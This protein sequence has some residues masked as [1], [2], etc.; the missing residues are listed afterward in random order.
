MQI[1]GLGERAV[2]SK[3]REGSGGMMN[4]IHDIT[5]GLLG[6]VSGNE[7]L[8]TEGHRVPGG[9]IGGRVTGNRSRAGKG[10]SNEMVQDVSDEG[11]Q[12]TLSKEVFTKYQSSDLIPGAKEHPGDIVEA[13]SLAAVPLPKA[14][15]DLAASIP[16]EL[17]TE[18]KLS[19]LQLEGILYTCQRHQ[20]VL[21]NGNRA[22]CF[23]GDAAG[24]GKG[25][26]IAGIILDN[27]CRG[28]TKHI[29]FS[30]SADL[31]VDAQR[32][33]HDLGCHIKVIEGCQ[34][35]DKETRVLGLP[36]DFQD[37]V[38]FSTYA[39]LVSSTQRGGAWGS[40]RQSRLE[41]LIQ[42][43]GGTEFNG[44]LV[45]DECHKAKHFIPGKEDTSTKVAVAVTAIQR[46]LPKAR[47][48]YCSATGVS[49][50][51]NMAFMER[52][53]MWGEGAS[54]ESFEKFLNA[55]NKRGLGVAEMMAMEMKASGMYV[56]R[57]LSFKQAEFVTVEMDLTDEQIK[58]Y[59]TAAHVWNELKKALEAALGRTNTGPTR[60]W[61]F[62]WSC[63]QRFFKQLCLGVK[64]PRIVEEAKKALDE[65]YCVV[66]GLQSTGEASMD[67]EITKAGSS[68][69]GFVSVA[70][71]TLIRFISQHFPTLIISDTGV[72][73][74]DEWS[75][76]AKTM[77]LGFAKEIQLPNSPLDD[78]I[79]QLGGASA[80]AE[81]TGRRGRMVRDGPNT[82]A[83]YQLRTPA[84][85]FDLNSLNVQERNSFMSG[86]KLVAIIS[87]AASTGISLH[88]DTRVKNQRRRLHLTIELPWSADKAVQQMG[89]SHR[90]NQ[91]SGPLYKLLTTN[92]GGER[93]F[94]ASVARRL[95]TLGALTQGD[96]RAATGA[97]LTQF[98]FDT[99]YG[100]SALKTMYMSICNNELATGV[101]LS[102]IRPGNIDADFCELNAELEE[103]L[104]LM[105]VMETY[106]SIG[107][108][109]NEND[110]K[111]VGRFLNRI[112]G[113]R[114]DRQN[115]I[116]NYFYECLQ[117]AI[118]MAKKEGKYSEGLVDVNAA[119]VEMICP[120]KTVFKEANTSTPTQLLSLSVDRGLSWEEAVERSKRFSSKND[121]FY[122]SKRE[123]FGKKLYILA[124]KKED[125]THLFKIAR[126]NTGVSHSDEDYSDLILRYRPIS[127]EDAEEGWKE[128][129]E[130]TKDKC[131]HGSHCKHPATCTIGSR[132]HRMDL[133]CGGIVTLLSTLEATVIKHAQKLDL[134]KASYSM[135]V[136]RV[137]LS[138]EKRVI[139]IRY[140]ECLVEIA[141][142]AVR[143]QKMI[144]ALQARLR[145]NAADDTDATSADLSQT[146]KL[147]TVEPESPVNPKLVKKAMTAP[148]T[149]NTFF[150]P[151]SRFESGKSRSSSPSESPSPSNDKEDT[152][153]SSAK[154]KQR[155]SKRG[156]RKTSRYS[157]IGQ[158]KKA[159]ECSK[160][161]AAGTDSDVDCCIMIE[162]QSSTTPQ[163]QN[164]M[165]QLKDCAP[166]Q[167][168]MEEV[169]D[170]SFGKEVMPA[171]DAQTERIYDVPD[172]AIP[173]PHN[174]MGKLPPVHSSASF[175]AADQL[176]SS[177]TVRS[178][179][180]NSFSSKRP[181]QDANGLT[182]DGASQQPVAKKQKPG[183]SLMESATKQG[184]QG[185]LTCPVCNQEFPTGTWLAQ[186]NKHVDACLLKA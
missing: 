49:D 67:S 51:K 88:A 143:E 62:F 180:A 94:A 186:L 44:C 79:D 8:M 11:V 73:R 4:G 101:T 14:I 55:I 118:A 128:Q 9:K 105:A 75:V 136:V 107:R 83:R 46:K 19:R 28:R 135:R 168:C 106:A 78:I 95:Q 155:G 76:T 34:Q 120:P 38:I 16:P 142:E 24:V 85:S 165:D 119:S 184:L 27:Y 116:F 13:A 97:D 148:V 123:Q 96:R 124:T 3:T 54:F 131:I 185:K 30:I 115:L 93:R 12:E 140:P 177:L 40:A 162:D 129:Y 90:S 70:R 57:G 33:F 130:A 22:G 166:K 32:D 37:G 41:Q 74:D 113:L 15:Y 139:G 56:S 144:E 112:L 153:C 35:L 66:I 147:A 132:L 182:T 77:L 122:C 181:L 68:Q 158:E 150:K 145:Q 65:G 176:G 134:S 23:I 160:T 29:W 43:C 18:G 137:A 174:I 50:V 138:D 36:K 5:P 71:E 82:Q 60:I 98:N 63:H 7:M 169:T 81:M 92:L 47:V 64:V 39:T 111:D 109:V 31:K 45:F 161:E 114:V 175:T 154:V 172:L 156:G 53:G 126:P 103:C 72:A 61:P 26:Q 86:K 102:A 159:L 10:E 157:P 117:S 127:M 171:E 17:I 99:P 58:M 21:P 110:R 164:G 183:T 179:S 48:L 59:D 125:S 87:D 42:W 151:T 91:T 6:N 52:L 141:E 1:D 146:P 163:M 89:R 80:V 84:D 100:R 170:P 104:S 121:G 149:L 2:R 20:T 69:S 152:I 178:N 133:L 173:S 25:R 108:K 167:G